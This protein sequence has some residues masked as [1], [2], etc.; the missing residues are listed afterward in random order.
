MTGR[1]KMECESLNPQLIEEVQRVLPAL[2]GGGPVTVR[3]SA[4]LARMIAKFLRAASEKG[5]VA[6]GPV[7]PKITPEQAAEIFDTDL[8]S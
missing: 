6:F 8:F 2:S 1:T 4:E 7:D 3:L 5:A